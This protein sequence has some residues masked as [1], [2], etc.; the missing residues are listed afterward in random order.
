[1]KKEKVS[2]GIGKNYC[3]SIGGEEFSEFRE[4]AKEE[5]VNFKFKLPLDFLP[6]NLNCHHCY[7]GL[8]NGFTISYDGNVYKCF[9]N[10][11]PPQNAIG[12]LNDFGEIDFDYP[13]YLRW[14]NYDYS[15]NT[16]CKNC[17]L[18]P[19]CMGG[20]ARRRLGLT[21]GLPAKCDQKKAISSAKNTIRSAY[22][23]NQ[24]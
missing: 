4:L 10:V 1:M 14:Y 15:T 2:T 9:G 24:N 21:P 22:E 17:I 7:V 12:V 8:D 18:L 23:L 16:N 13:E 3:G 19:V 5:L 6:K 11:N 20:C